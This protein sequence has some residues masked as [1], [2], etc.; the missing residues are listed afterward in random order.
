MGRLKGD[1]G[2][3]PEERFWRRV[4]KTE[5]CWLFQGAHNGKGYVV[6]YAAGRIYAHQY[7]YVLHHGPVPLGLKVLHKCDVRNCV[8]PEHLYCG[9]D[10]DNM[11]DMI[12]RGRAPTTEQRRERMLQ[13][14]PRGDQHWTRRMPEKVLRGD[15]HWRRRTNE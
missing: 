10:V 12:A 3:S 7:S 2:L 13:S 5:E 15:K 8:R 9:T 6:F 14:A 11:R 1:L 4:V